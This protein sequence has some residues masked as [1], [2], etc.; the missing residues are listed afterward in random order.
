MSTDHL[1]LTK[2]ITLIGIHGKAG[3]GKDT[4]S[5]YLCTHYKDTYSE[6][7]AKAL[8]RV[9]SEAFGLPIANFYER[10]IKEVADAYWDYSPRHLAQFIGTEMFRNHFGQD[11]WIKRLHGR[12]EN[13]LN[14]GEEGEY[15]DGDFVVIPDVR[16]Q[17]E[18]DWILQN[19][20]II[21]HVVKEG[22]T[23]EVGIKNHA[24]EAGI[25]FGQRFL[26]D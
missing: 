8:K 3:A 7:F 10:D 26:S 19:G 1:T 23:G 15:E 5:D 16:F 13:I 18:H 9:A 20:G 11:F 12:L 22:A 17:N 25:A 6:P 4:V 21:L 14:T 2:K 24:S